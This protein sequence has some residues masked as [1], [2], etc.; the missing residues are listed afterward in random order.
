[1]NHPKIRIQPW[2]TGWLAAY[3][4][5]AANAFVTGHVGGNFCSFQQPVRIFPLARTVP[6]TA[7]Q[8]RP[9]DLK[10]VWNSN[11]QQIGQ[12]HTDHPSRPGTIHQLAYNA[13]SDVTFP[14]DERVKTVLLGR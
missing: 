12:F 10:K 11:Y 9:A 13:H 4:H 14:T 6:Y 1:M 8:E 3:V 7:R 2:T 5:S